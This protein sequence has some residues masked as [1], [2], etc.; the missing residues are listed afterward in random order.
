MKHISTI[1]GILLL[2]DFLF[3]AGT[4]GGLENDTL[5]FLEA[6]INMMIAFPFCWILTKI[7]NY[8][9]RYES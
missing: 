7:L 4:C 6:G 9:Y 1:A 8:T 3:I 2:V 5:T